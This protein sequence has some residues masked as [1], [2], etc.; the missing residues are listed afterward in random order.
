MKRSSGMPIKTARARGGGE[1]SDGVSGPI[2]PSMKMNHARAAANTRPARR[3]LALTL[4]SI[5]FLLVPE[6]A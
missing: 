2:S 4:A 5:S 3:S 1:P 6:F